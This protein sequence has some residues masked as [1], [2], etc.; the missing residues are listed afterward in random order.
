MCRAILVT[1]FLAASGAAVLDGQEQTSSP[2]NLLESGKYQQAVDAVASRG[3]AAAPE[4]LYV[5]GQSLNR[6]DRH[7]EARETFARIDKGDEENAWTFVARSAIAAVDGNRDAALDA[8][9]RAV[10]ISP[11]HFQ[12]QYQLGLVKLQNE[13]FGGAA[14]AFDRATRLDGNDAYAHY[15]AGVAFNKIRRLDK[16][17]EHFRAF[18][19]LAPSAPERPQVETILRTLRR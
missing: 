1:L 18:V 4:E 13:D 8:A 14:D 3:D 19:Q 10:A 17:T 6:L 12:A 5:A 7:G 16:M 15:Y 9:N 11:D 2:K